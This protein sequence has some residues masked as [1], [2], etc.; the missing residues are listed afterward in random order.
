MSFR[1]CG[2]RPSGPSAETLGRR[3]LLSLLPS[4]EMVNKKKIWICDGSNKCQDVFQGAF[5]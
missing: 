5:V 2:H 3:R 4:A 1:F